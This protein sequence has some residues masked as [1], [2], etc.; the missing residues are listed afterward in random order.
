VHKRV[1]G[2]DFGSRRIGVAIS[3]PLRLIARS[4]T[5]VQNS[6]AAVDEIRR[7]TEEYDV[8]TIAVGLPLNLKGESGMKAAEVEEFI[9]ALRQAISCTIVTVDERFT[10]SIAAATLRTMGTKKSSRK[11]K[12]TIDAMAAALIAQ[13]YLDRERAGGGR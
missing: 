11:V 7:I 3:D 5:V 2:I 12:G 13:S 9:V 6:P 1:L 10:S 8:D 4:L